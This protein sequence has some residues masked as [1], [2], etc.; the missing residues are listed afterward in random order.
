MRYMLILIMA[1]N[2]EGNLNGD[3]LFLNEIGNKPGET[4]FFN[5]SYKN[6]AIM[7]SFSDRKKLKNLSLSLNKK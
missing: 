5:G 7:G 4:P 2:L 3:I 6:N 1:V